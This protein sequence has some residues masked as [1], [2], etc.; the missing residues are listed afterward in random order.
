MLSCSS[1]LDGGTTDE[2]K[3]EKDFYFAYDDSVEVFRSLDY[4]SIRPTADTNTEQLKELIARYDLRPVSRFDHIPFKNISEHQLNSTLPIVLRIPSGYDIETFY[5]SGDCKQ[6]DCFAVN[7]AI[8]YSVPVYR[9]KDE[10]NWHW[11]YLNDRIAIGPH[12]NE[13]IPEELI[14]KFDLEFVSKNSIA[15]IYSYKLSSF[16]FGNT[17]TVS[18]ELFQQ[19]AFRYVVP[20]KYMQLVH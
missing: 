16:E 7:T 14:D 3:F 17:L 6:A 11:F 13:P 2:L 9:F 10:N 8:Q 12:P 19:S 20:D 4:I 1:A 15:E 5:S 18:R